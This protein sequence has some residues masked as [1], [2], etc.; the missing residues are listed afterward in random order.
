MRIPFIEAFGLCLALALGVARAETGEPPATSAMPERARLLLPSCTVL[1]FGQVDLVST[2]RVELL[3][4]G[5]ELRYDEAPEEPGDVAV[6]LVDAPSCNGIDV[7]I[8]VD[9]PQTGRSAS[10][11]LDI[12][13]SQLNERGRIL[14]LAIA[15]LLRTEWPALSEPL[16]EEPPH[17]DEPEVEG[18]EEPGP[19]TQ[20]IDEATFLH[21]AV[22]AM[23]RELDRRERETRARLHMIM[24]T[25]A[26]SVRSYPVVQGGLLG[27]QVGVSFRLNRAV[28]VYLE[29]DVGYGLGGG[30]VSIGDIQVQ[31][32]IGGLVLLYAGGTN[33]IRGSIGSRLELGWGWAE[34]QPYSPDVR[35]RSVDGFIL[36]IALTGGVRVRVSPRVLVL[37]DG[38]AGW[39]AASLE[40]RAEGRHVGGIGRVLLGINLG[41][42]VGL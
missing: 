31:T 29:I 33:R 3:G 7:T 18:P 28:P 39:V 22:A 23:L 15:E 11:S 42:A 19:E 27:G 17:D 36:S 5:T 35:S 20:Q 10:R 2:L 16:D 26:L 30:T 1:P 14:A 12:G 24:I 41:I 6:I 32:V 13:D 9:D 4:Y 21:N 34:G 38:L 37:L 40:P 25:A 8:R